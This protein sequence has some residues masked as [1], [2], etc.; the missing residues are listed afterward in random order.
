MPI[1][2][3][4]DPVKLADGTVIPIVRYQVVLWVSLAHPSELSL[5]SK[6]PRFPAIFDSAFNHTFLI[7]EEHLEQ[8]AGLRSQQFGLLE[9]R[10]VY[11]EAV[12][13][14]A[15]NVWL[16]ANVPGKRVQL[17]TRPPF[18]IQLDSGIG[19]CPRGSTRPRLPLLGL[20]ALFAADLRL[21]LDCA[22]GFASLR[23]P[24]RFWLFG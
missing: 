17:A 8:W 11:G 16:H 3:T 23:S 24:N 10:R 19:V 1:H 12:P 15:V 7:R 4:T 6:T 18:R 21:N 20:R 9:Y 14:H 13:W 22:R 5:H 2:V